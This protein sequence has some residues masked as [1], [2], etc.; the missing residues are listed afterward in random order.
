MQ[1]ES[2]P[3]RLAAHINSYD[4][5]DIQLAVGEKINPPLEARS[6]GGRRPVNSRSCHSGRVKYFNGLLSHDRLT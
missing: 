6:D 4:L 5:I 3:D 1:N 2:D